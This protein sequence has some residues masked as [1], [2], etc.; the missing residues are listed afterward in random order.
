MLP[1]RCQHGTHVVGIDGMV[2]AEQRCGLQ[3]NA[4][5]PLG[6][7]FGKDRPRDA[8]LRADRIKMG[9]DRAGAVG[10]GQDVGA[11]L[12]GCAVAE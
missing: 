4:A 6:P 8:D 7:Q 3:G 9:A 1:H 10:E 2:D 11:D 12:S 5:G